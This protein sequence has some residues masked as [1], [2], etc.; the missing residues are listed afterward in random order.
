M[1][2]SDIFDYLIHGELSQLSLTKSGVIDVDD[3][4]RIITNINLGLIELYK[5]FQLLTK[6]MPMDLRTTIT[7]YNLHSNYAQT[8][9][10]SAEPIKYLI[11]SVDEPFLDDILLITH[12]YDSDGIELPLNDLNAEWSVFTP[13]PF[14]LEVPTLTED[15]SIVFSYRANPPIINYDIVTDPTEVEIALPVQFL[16]AL[17]AYVAWRMFSP[18][19]VGEKAEA[20]SYYAKFEASCALINDLGMLNMDNNRNQRFYENGW[21]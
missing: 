21:V 6:N 1:L 10:A 20:N 8:N 3:Y 12:V 17:T 9:T 4:P 18:I 14:I 11:D 7:R 13:S 15:I 5:R 2:L 19:N 16:E